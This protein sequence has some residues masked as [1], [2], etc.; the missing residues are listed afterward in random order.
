MRETHAS[1]TRKKKGFGA[2]NES[3]NRGKLIID[4]NLCPA[5]I[6][7][8]TDFGILKQSKFTRKKL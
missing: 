2:K 8:P 1:Q 4:A 3:T 5:D 7:Y 6:T